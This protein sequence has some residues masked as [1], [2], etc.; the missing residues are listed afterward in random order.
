MAILRML[1]RLTPLHLPPDQRPDLHNPARPLGAVLCDGGAARQWP[2][3]PDARPL[4][5]ER[6]LAQLIDAQGARRRQLLE[7]AITI[8]GREAALLR[9]PDGTRGLDL[10]DVAAA[11]LGTLPPRRLA[12]PYY[13]VFERARPSAS[14]PAPSPADPAHA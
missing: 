5:S 12:E 14:P 1:V 9:E 10:R 4:L 6:R 3:A 13:A 7:R 2:A 8:L 11:A